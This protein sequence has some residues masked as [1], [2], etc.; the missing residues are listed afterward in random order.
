MKLSEIENLFFSINVQAIA[1]SQGKFLD[2]VSRW[3]SSTH[4]SRIF[5]ISRVNIKYMQ[6]ELEDATW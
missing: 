2:I 4:D 3:V 5:N 6:R 1:G